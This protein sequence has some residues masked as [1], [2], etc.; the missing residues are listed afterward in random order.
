METETPGQDSK[1]AKK[2]VMDY[3]GT[4]AII[5]IVLGSIAGYLY[6]HYVGCRSGSCPI[7]SNPT[8]STIWGA[9]IGYLIGDMFRKRSS[10]NKN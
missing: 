4:G 1:K 9:I 2:K 3:I 6:Y 8:I 10:G 5:G 7:N